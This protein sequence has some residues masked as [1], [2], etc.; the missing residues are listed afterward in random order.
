[1]KLLEYF[2]Y[3]VCLYGELHKGKMELH[4]GVSGLKVES[5]CYVL[6]FDYSDWV[7]F[8]S[9]IYILHV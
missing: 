3:Q 4:T 8:C 1:M 2:I 9:L 7:C 5:Y 6:N